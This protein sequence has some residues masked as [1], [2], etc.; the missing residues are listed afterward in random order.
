[1]AEIHGFDFQTGD[2]AQVRY[3]SPEKEFTDLLLT[4]LI[5]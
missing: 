3:F 5:S 1:V 2:L 4:N